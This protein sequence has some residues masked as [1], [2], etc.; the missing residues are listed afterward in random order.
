M[1]YHTLGPC[2]CSLR[3][4]QY[5]SL[6]PNI[7]LYCPP[8]LMTITIIRLYLAEMTKVQHHLPCLLCTSSPRFSLPSRR[9]PGGW[10]TKTK[11]GNR[12]LHS[13]QG[14]LLSLA[15]L[16]MGCVL[17]HCSLDLRTPQKDFPGWVNHTCCIPTHCMVTNAT[18]SPTTPHK[19]ASAIINYWCP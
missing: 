10:S 7:L 5:C 18:S 13:S 17:W 8:T 1:D 19:P 15:T 6:E 12:D 16:S 11:R 14:A 3:S 9:L 2:L 4:C